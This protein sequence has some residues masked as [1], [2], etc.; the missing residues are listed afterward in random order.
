MLRLKRKKKGKWA[1]DNKCVYYT[2]CLWNSTLKFLP[3]HT[4]FKHLHPFAFLAYFLNHLLVKL[5]NGWLL[6]REIELE[7]DS[8]ACQILSQSVLFLEC[9]ECKKGVVEPMTCIWIYWQNRRS[10][11][12]WKLFAQMIKQHFRH[13]GTSLTDQNPL[14]FL[15]LEVIHTW[16]EKYTQENTIHAF[17]IGNTFLSNTSLKMAEKQVILAMINQN[18]NENDNYTK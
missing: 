4:L 8:T 14:F 1:E 17:F 5:L 7:I 15:P 10:K 9:R 16:L 11:L 13:L 6:I 2:L 12:F 18:E 3:I